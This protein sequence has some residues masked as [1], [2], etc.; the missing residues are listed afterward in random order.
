MALTFPFSQSIHEHTAGNF[1]ARPRQP[2][3]PQETSQLPDV[4]TAHLTDPKQ[5]LSSSSRLDFKELLQLGY[6]LL[7]DPAAKSKGDHAPVFGSAN[8]KHC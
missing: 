5:Q 1:S 3:N 2:H 7:V 4:P 8:L 6:L